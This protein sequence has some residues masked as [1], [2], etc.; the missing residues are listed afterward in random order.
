MQIPE[1][2]LSL[3]QLLNAAGFEAYFVG[4]CVRD[5][6]LGRIPHDWDICTSALPAQVTQVFKQQ[7]YAVLQTGVAHGTVTVLAQGEPFEIT[8]FRQDGA[9]TDHR[10]PD[11]VTLGVSLEQDLA[12]R[13]FTINAMALSPEGKLIDPFGGRADLAAKV[14]RCV[15]TPET[16]FAED[17]LRILRS[18]RF[19]SVL[20]FRLEAHTFAAAN[21]LAPQLKYVAAERKFA[22]LQKLLLGDD[23]SRALRDG[24]RILCHI[25]PE[26]E[27]CIGLDLKSA[28]H[29][30]TL[31]QHIA[32]AVGLA[33]KDATLRMAL[34]L[35]DIAKPRCFT[36]DDKGVGHSYGHANIGAAMSRSILAKLKVP[37][38]L[39]D[40]VFALIKYHDSQLPQNPAG[41][42]RWLAKLGETRLRQLLEVKKADIAAHAPKAAQGRQDALQQFAD[43]MEEQLRQNACF[44]LE[45]LAVKGADLLAA[46]LCAPGPQMG[47]LLQ[48]LLNEV[49]EGRIP[50]QKTALLAKAQQL[51]K[52]NHT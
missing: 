34:L 32:D 25:I 43:L 49:I 31:W 35:H 26:I 16:R 30:R 33:P 4:G 2:A 51:C 14:I 1:T 17:A 8:T 18:V 13:D 29:D 41:V 3:A 40:E 6:L 5:S 52:K 50:N 24:A 11:A 10:R 48:D 23:A 37:T 44:R 7:G 20:G 28:Y 39:Q 22:E 46:D 38:A 36:V 9:Y 15:G 12:R 42:R 45:Q 19:A 21:A 27:P 47:R